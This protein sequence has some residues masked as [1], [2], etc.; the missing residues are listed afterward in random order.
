MGANFTDADDT[1]LE[2][3]KKDH[4]RLE[5]LIAYGAQIRGVGGDHWGV[6]IAGRPLFT[7]F[8]PTPRAAIDLAIGMLEYGLQPKG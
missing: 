7:R 8:T 5:F 3:L 6:W 2:D 1:S 4:Y